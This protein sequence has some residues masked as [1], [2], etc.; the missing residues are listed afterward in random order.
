MEVLSD[1]RPKGGG[2]AMTTKERTVWLVMDYGG[3]WEDA[4]ECPVRAFATR[5]RAEE[6][7]EKRRV[8]QLGDPGNWDYRNTMVCPVQLVERGAETPRQPS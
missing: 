4:W 1:L 6:C 2:K 7:A 8:R 5:E 3:E